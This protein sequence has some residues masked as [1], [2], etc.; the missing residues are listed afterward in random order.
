MKVEGGKVIK[1]EYKLTRKNGELIES[2]SVKGPLEFVV[3][4]GQFL[5]GLERKMSGMEAGESRTFFL[6]PE[7]AFGAKD[8]GPLHEMPKAEF[9]QGTEFKMG[10]RFMA[11]LGGID[12]QFEVV[13]NKVDTVVVRLHHPLEGETVTAEVTIVDVQDPN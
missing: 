2:S 1:I 8:S 10:A 11:K 6:D 5:A 13:E 9:P 7:D 4:K 12:L 3:G